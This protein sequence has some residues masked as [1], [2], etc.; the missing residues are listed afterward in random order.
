MISNLQDF[1]DMCLELW[2]RW[3]IDTPNEIPVYARASE[4]ITRDVML[5][6][7]ETAIYC[8]AWPQPS[9]KEL[10]ADIVAGLRVNKLTN[11]I[12]RSLVTL[13]VVPFPEP[14]DDY[15]EDCEE[16]MDDCGNH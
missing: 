9:S 7:S 8:G 14:I 11:P 15:C 6:I 16:C 13:R 10:E 1:K 12:T 2:T 5:P 3:R 4:Q